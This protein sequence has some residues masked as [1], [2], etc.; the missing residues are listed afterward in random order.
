MNFPKKL[1]PK[2][3]PLNPRSGQ[4]LVEVL[5]AV[6]IGGL[7]IGSAVVAI[8]L[9]LTSGTKTQ[10]VGS[11]TPFASGLSD[12]AKSVAEGDWNS[13]YGL[14]KTTGCPSNC[15]KYYFVRDG[16]LKIVNGEEGVLGED[17]VTGL[18]GYWKFDESSGTTAYDATLN[19][20]KGTLVA[21]PSTPTQAPNCKVGRCLDFDGTDDYLTLPSGNFFNVDVGVAKTFSVWFNGTLNSGRDSTILWQDGNCIGWAIHM[22]SN[23]KLKTILHT[24]AS[25]CTGYNTYTVNPSTN[26]SD[27]LWHHAVA[28]VDRPNLLMTLYVDGVSAGT[29]AV[30]NT[31]SGIGGSARVGTNYNNGTA[32]NGSIDDV[33][34]YKRAL[35]AA[36]VKQLYSSKI[37]T[38]SFTVTNVNRDDLGRGSIVTS[39]GAEDP[40]TQKVVA[41]VTPADG[42]AAIS[43]IEYLVR[44]RNSATLFTDWSGGVDDSGVYTSPT[45]KYSA[46]TGIDFEVVGEIKASLP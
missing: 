11:A 41:T 20:K 44:S 34:I 13:V 38:R 28:V 14:D 12:T 25:G 22:A 33:R 9:S 43:S 21:S 23:G 16:S 36:E 45:N 46:A 29:A 10:T 30:D 37:Y 18:V 26:Y 2:P 42:S 32:F 31:A 40:S 8:R 35:T 5:V 27:G 1:N 17:V 24:G 19:N 6:T 15:P 4:S 3:Y 39:G 7:I